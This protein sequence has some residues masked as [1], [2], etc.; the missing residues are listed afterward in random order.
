M[1]TLLC[2]PN[3]IAAI[4]TEVL[5]EDHE[6]FFRAPD[7][8]EAL[9]S[10]GKVCPSV[11]IVGGESA[12]KVE[13]SCKELRASQACRD[14]V[15]VAVS[16]R[17]EDARALVEAGADDFLLTDSTK[18]VLRSRLFV[19]RRAADRRVTER[20]LADS[21]ATTLDC[22]HDGVITT[23]KTGA[24]VCMN[25]VAQ[26]LTGWTFA[27]AE[28]RSLEDVCPITRAT[29]VS[30]E[31]FLE[32]RDGREITIA[33][34]CAAIKTADGTING[35][36]LVFREVTVEAEAQRQLAVAERM[37]SVGTL[38]AGLAHE[39]NNPLSY[40]TANVDMALEEVHALRGGSSLGQI[41]EVETMLH[42][43]REGATRVMKIIRELG[44]YTRAPELEKTNIIDL[45]A[46]IEVSIIRAFSPFHHRAHVA[47]SFRAVPLVDVNADWLGRAF[48]N[49]L[50][51]AGQAFATRDPTKNEIRVG[52][53]TDG[54]GC[55]VVT[56]SD[57]GAGIAPELVTRVFD[58]FFTTKPIG[59]STG[60]GLAAS[61]NIVIALGGDITVE[62]EL[63]R[64]TT[65]R[66]TLPASTT[67]DAA[68]PAIE[69]TTASTQ[70]PISVLVV[71][72]ERAI[73]MAIRRVLHDHDVTVVSAGQAALDL[74]EGGTTFDLVLCDLMMPSMSGMDFHAALEREHPEMAP[75]VVFVTGGAFTPEASAFL[76]RVGNARLQKPFDPNALRALALGSIHHVGG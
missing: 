34:S 61:R 47:R 59:A 29:D 39:I 62:S 66:V 27:E 71:D 40:V 30:T 33:S 31:A 74:L 46:V 18:E 52:T 11:V 44:T 28:G 64:G 25:P 35:A 21:L 9:R 58:P 75:K 14:A 17:P 68:A 43:A 10:A 42:D 23:N 26:T 73:G 22:I 6:I 1:N 41:E 19:A 67:L 65:V 60:L 49:I 20:A 70:R 16:E 48:D 32:R 55:A 54:R 76:R 2:T 13:M 24:I 69:S 57:N 56:I 72:D 63:G 4:A 50:V 7:L 51:N 36:V 37:A 38:A 3:R 45:T 12:R 5:S 8:S 53:S 15:I